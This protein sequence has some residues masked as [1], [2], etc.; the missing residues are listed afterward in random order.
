MIQNNNYVHPLTME[1]IPDADIN[2]AKELNK[3]YTTNLGMFKNTDETM[4][5]ELRL[6]GRLTMYSKNFTSIAYILMKIG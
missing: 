5:A 3:W 1:A 4:S 6:M 2:R